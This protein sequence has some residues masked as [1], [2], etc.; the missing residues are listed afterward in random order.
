MNRFP[1]SLLVINDKCSYN[2]RG[3]GT[4]DF[5]GEV[6][7]TVCGVV[8]RVNKLVYVRAQ[9][10]RSLLFPNLI[11]SFLIIAL[12]FMVEFNALVSM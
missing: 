12:C 4:T 11:I 10:A 6:V 2:V 9:R 5:N 1:I 7:A 3:H 8:E